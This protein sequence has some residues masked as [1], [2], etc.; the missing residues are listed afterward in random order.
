MPSI[1]KDQ[2]NRWNAKAQGGFGFAMK[3]YVLWGEKTLRRTDK[4][5]NGNLLEFRLYFREEIVMKSSL[6]GNQYS[7]ATGRQIPVLNV[8]EWEPSTNDMYVSHGLGE[9]IDLGPAVDKK[10]YDLLCKLSG[11][12]GDLVR[13]RIDRA[14]AAEEV[15]TV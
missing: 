9:E 15:K 10:Q 13:A 11:T 6:Y 4:L 2:F 7:V 12:V 8:S 5:Q 3:F 1:T 14:N